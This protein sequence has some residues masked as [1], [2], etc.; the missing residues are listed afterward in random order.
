MQRFC[1]KLRKCLQYF[2]MRIAF[3]GKGGSGKTT[4]SSLFALYA[5]GKKYRVGL[6]DIDVNSHTTKLLGAPSRPCLSEAK[7]QTEI[8]KYLAGKNTRVKPDE[9]LNTTPPGQGSNSWRLAAD[10]PI[11]KKYGAPFGQRS[12]VFTLGSYTSAGIGHSCHHGT[13][14]VAE[15]MLSHARL[16]TDDVIVIDS[17]AGNDSFANTLYYQDVLVFVVKPEREGVDVFKRYYDL[18][19]KAGIAG[20]VKVIANQ[21]TSDVQRS[22]LRRELPPGVLVGENSLN[23]KITEARFD[24]SPLTLDMVSDELANIFDEIIKFGDDNRLSPRD[25]YE[26]FVKTHRKLCQESWV[27]GAYR[28]GLEDQIDEEFV[29]E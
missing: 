10:A 20:R 6:L 3:L 23:D 18:A 29:C 17:V 24:D 19:K 26:H 28:P 5:D 13:Q 2:D 7:S 21:V 27:H 22:F 16:A 9:M 25:Y 14:Y 8:T 1:V 4:L 12:F 11:T 15:N